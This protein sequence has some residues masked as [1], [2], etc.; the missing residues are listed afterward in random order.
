MLT[1]IHIVSQKIYAK[2]SEKQYEIEDKLA[3]ESSTIITLRGESE[4]L[5][6]GG[7]TFITSVVH[8]LVFPDRIE[9][10]REYE[11]KEDL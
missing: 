9:F 2:A 10:Q 11:M 3:N 1:H 6:K 5:P 4:F 8:L 7:K